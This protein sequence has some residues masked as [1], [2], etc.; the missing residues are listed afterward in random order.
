MNNKKIAF[1]TCVNDDILYEECLRYIS[2]LVIPEGY[3]I[4]TIAIKEAT[5]MTSGYNEAMKSTDAKYKVYLHQDTF[6]INK[7]FINDIISI[8]KLDD[9]IGIIGMVGSKNIPN[10]A[11]WWEASKKYGKVYESHTGNIKILSFDEGDYVYEEV[12]AIDGLIMITQQDMFWREDLFEGWHFYDISQ[13]LEFILAGYKVIVPDQKTPWCIHDCGLVNIKNGY[14]KY[15]EVL[16]QNYKE[17]IHTEENNK[18]DINFYSIGLN[19]EFEDDCIFINP[20]YIRL[21]NNIKICAKSKFRTLENFSEK[22]KI[23]IDDNC[24]I[25]ERCDLFAIN[26]IIINS[27]VNIGNNVHI[28]DCYE[29]KNIGIPTITNDRLYKTNRLII[30]EGSIIGNNV[31]IKGNLTIGKNSIIESNSVVYSDIP[32]RCIAVG[33]PAKIV[34]AFDYEIGRWIKVENNNQLKIILDKRSDVRP[35]LTIGIPTYNRAKRLDKC[36][37][38]IYSQIGDDPLIEV[39]VSDNCSTD[40]TCNIVKRYKAKYKNLTYNRNEKNIVQ[41]NFQTVL[42]LAKGK[43]V[44]LHGDDDYFESN[45]IYNIVNMIYNN[46]GC[47]MMTL[48]DEKGDCKIKRGIGINEYINNMEQWITFITALIFNK[49]EYN[50][51]S[52]KEKEYNTK[53]FNQVHFSFRLLSKN[54]E[55]CILKGNV[56]REDCG[57][58]QMNNDGSSLDTGKIFIE[59][60]IDLLNSFKKYGVLD[61]TLKNFKYKLLVNHIIPQICNCKINGRKSNYQETVDIFKRYY[62]DE[63]YYE[64]ALKKL[65]EIINV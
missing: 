42:E 41:K 5:S 25:G 23:I 30:G 12:K 32:D 45:V 44:E 19:N 59:D 34:E 10:N 55:F 11:I 26:K 48:L 9:S 58:E 22:A 29:Y 54:P 13:C 57:E 61:E 65:N 15:K 43:Y 17:H 20:Q 16:L 60:L 1:I 2:N 63:S 28:I 40:N 24:I 47:S 52:E 14:D 36:L 37:K 33:S 35:I 27:R 39:L 51:L 64:I 8:F 53:Y 3:E 7:N 21:N 31:V 46:L 4:D 18:Y 56:Y 50:N 49:E 62:C 38:N 6:I